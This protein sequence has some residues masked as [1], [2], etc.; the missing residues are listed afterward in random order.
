MSGAIQH[1]IISTKIRIRRLETEN[2]TFL[3]GV[4]SLNRRKSSEIQKVHSLTMILYSWK[5]KGSN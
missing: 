4:F 2:K 1:K 5:Y 3:R